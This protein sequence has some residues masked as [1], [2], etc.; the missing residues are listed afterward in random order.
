MR[1]GFHLPQW[2]D[3]ATRDGVVAVARKVEE[4]GLDAVW[5]ADHVVLPTAST[6]RYPYS[7]ETPFGPEDGFLE[8]LTTLAVVAGATERVR[9]GTS[10]LVMPMRH[11]VLTAK[12][13]ATIDVLSGGRLVLAMGAGWWEEEFEALDATFAGRGVRMDEQVQ[14]MRE[15]WRLGTTSF[16]GEFYR[17]PE[18]ACEPRP[19]QPGGPPV[20]IGGMNPRALRRAG[21]LG[22]GWHA[23]GVAEEVLSQGMVAVRGA[24]EAAGRDPDRVQLSTSTVLPGDDERTLRRLLRLARIGVSDVVLDVPGKTIAEICQIIEGFAEN[25]LP[26]VR[27]ETESG[28]K[29]RSP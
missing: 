19:L 5:V 23:V 24:A 3:G 11:P 6:S 8:A 26:R 20:L 9:L 21:E 10:V 4:V 17:F 25:T 18:L 22:D 16:S 15:L 7:E 27:D 13:A 28:P 14:V 1:I 2:G 29:T 12:V